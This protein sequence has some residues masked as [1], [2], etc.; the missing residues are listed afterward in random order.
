MERRS[1]LKK[2]GAGIAVG[3]AAGI[4]WGDMVRARDANGQPVYMRDRIR[5]WESIGKQAGILETERHEP[6]PAV[7]S[8]FAGLLG[9]A[10][11]LA[12][13]RGEVI[14]AEATETET[15]E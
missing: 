7:T 14:D 6:P 5:V 3:A 9:L 11:G 13:Q 1:F 2:A 4:L 12:A 10:V 15:D 8:A